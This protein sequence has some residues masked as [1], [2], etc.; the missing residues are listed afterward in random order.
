MKSTLKMNIT[1][2]V[3]GLVFAAPLAAQDWVG[4]VEG[5]L[6]S[7][8]RTST[9]TTIV[10][11]PYTGYFVAG[12]TQR[13][14]GDYRLSVDGRLE[15]M[16]DK[17]IDDVDKTGPVHS[18]VIGLHFGREFGDAYFGAFAAAGNFDGYESNSPMTG[19]LAGLEGSYT[20][21]IG[22]VLYAQVGAMEAIGD[23]DDNEYVGY[24]AR[25]G[26]KHQFNDRISAGL[27]YEFGQSND[28]F[29]DCPD[30]EN[31][32]DEPGVFSMVT[33]DASY[34]VTD[35][36]D[37]VARYAYLNVFDEDD[38]DTGTESTFYLGARWNFGARSEQTAL[39]TPMGGFQA[40]GWMEPLD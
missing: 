2:V 27:S 5:G 32:V 21:P 40:A 37:I 4:S 20:L 17:D 7:T 18:G 9:D 1:T 30:D 12:Q 11:S 29:V 8:D 16:D 23:P 39:T 13:N 36:M 28:C 22:A 14:F 10:D 31:E 34:A 33:L 24:A 25:V 3:F 38:D 35:Q 15:M 19:T 26:A 6:F